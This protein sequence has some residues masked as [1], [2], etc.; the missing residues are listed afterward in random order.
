M[1]VQE[2]FDLFEGTADAVFTVTDQG[3]MCSWNEAAERIFDFGNAEALQQGCQSL[4]QGRGPLGVQ[5][6]GDNCSIR[7][8]VT[9]HLEIPNFDLEVKICSALQIWVSLSTLVYENPLNHRRLV[10][11][12][13]HA[14]TEKKKNEELL[15]KKTN[16]S[17]I[18]QHS[19]RCC[20][21]RTRVP[22]L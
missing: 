1:L 15:R 22:I 6:W 14:I 21:S 12:F 10:V 16:L 20:A 7:D 17:T 13:G 11:H 3:E 2:L 5:V 18:G 8:Y 4:L 9:R 19:G